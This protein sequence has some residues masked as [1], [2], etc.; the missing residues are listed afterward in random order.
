MEGSVQL[1]GG[2]TADK[3]DRPRRGQNMEPTVHSTEGK[4]FSLRYLS[5]GTFGLMSRYRTPYC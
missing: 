2:N 3:E 1:G 5:S 4:V